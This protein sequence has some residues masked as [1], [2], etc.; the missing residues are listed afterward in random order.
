MKKLILMVFSLTFLVSIR[1]QDLSDLQ[2]MEILDRESKK[3]ESSLE[4]FY[5]SRSVLR[6]TAPQVLDDELDAD[7]YIVGPGD[8]FS[9]HIFGELETVFSFNVLPEGEVD[10][11]TVGSISINGLSLREAKEKIHE[12][13]RANYIKADLSIKIVSLRKFRVYLTGEVKLPG[14]F[15][16]QGSDRVS[17]IIEV[18]DGLTD[19]ADETN[20]EIIRLDGTKKV[21]DLTRFYRFSDK[22]HNPPVRGGDIINAAPIDLN[23]PYVLVESRIDKTPAMTANQMQRINA[24]KSTRKI[25]RLLDDEIVIDFLNRISAYSAEVDL[26]N[27]TLRREAREIRIDLLTNF[28]NYNTFKLQSKDL[29]IIPN[30]ISEVY[31]QGEV[32]QPGSFPF[33]ANLTARDYAG[34]A[35]VIE[36]AVSVKDFRIFR[37]ASGKIDKGG[38]LIVEKGDMVIV[39]RKR[40]ETFKDYL[41]IVVPIFSIFISTY[42]ILTR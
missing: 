28:E 2:R 7:E 8:Q 18:G 39:P 10:I 19:W 25:F 5:K 37:A 14:T 40:R 38:D 11:P 12:K 15:F 41:A 34:M 16:A 17:D 13:V 35:G 31:V 32:M 27:I 26:S 23:R 30:I 36:T 6:V 22:S 29:L 33:T 9:L 4:R 21:V 24:E 20:I 42:T 3:Y 1:A